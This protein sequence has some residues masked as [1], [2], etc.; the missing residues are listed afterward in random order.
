M[1]KDGYR[2]YE[3]GG[4]RPYAKRFW[5]SRPRTERRMCS[6]RGPRSVSSRDRFA[7]F[8]DAADRPVAV[9]ELQLRSNL[10]VNFDGHEIILQ[11]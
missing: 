1:S 9:F 6:D 4:K 10:K 2:G 8:I 11:G 3:R 5:R 7:R